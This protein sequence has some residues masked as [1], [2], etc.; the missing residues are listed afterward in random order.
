MD[1]ALSVTNKR[2]SDLGD[3]N[4]YEFVEATIRCPPAEGVE[5]LSTPGH[6]YYAFFDPGDLSTLQI[7]ADQLDCYIKSEGPFDAVLAFSAGCVVVAMYL[8]Q[9]QR[10][11][12]E[13]PFK[14]AVFLSSAGI[15]HEAEYMG[16]DTTRCLIQIPT[17][18][19]WGSN[20]V[21]APNG[22][23][24]LCNMCEPLQRLVWVHDGGHE[25]PR[26][27]DLTKA[28]HVIQQVMRMALGRAR[29]EKAL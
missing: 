24:D 9:K 29:V 14:C 27:D 28:G 3:S 1:G 19:I 2:W 8:M 20:D 18:H 5:A 22:G 11:S 10:Q 23:Q 7:A 4:E 26:G 17:A 13:A 6:D 21:T 12:L 25:L 15:R 16:M